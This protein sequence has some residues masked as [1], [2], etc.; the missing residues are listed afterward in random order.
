[1]LHPKASTPPFFLMEAYALRTIFSFISIIEIIHSLNMGHEAFVS[2][3]TALAMDGGMG[4]SVDY[5]LIALGGGD[6][7]SPERTLCS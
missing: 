3:L 2:G 6:S 5:R 4:L 1:M 7:L